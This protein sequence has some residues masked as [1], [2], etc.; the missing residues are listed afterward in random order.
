MSA[1][2]KLL[3]LVH[4]HKCLNEAYINKTLLVLNM[5]RKTCSLSTIIDNTDEN[6]KSQKEDEND[7]LETKVGCKAACMQVGSSNCTQA[8]AV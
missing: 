3:C 5:G 7:E 8:V 4:P 6:D 1:I 2:L